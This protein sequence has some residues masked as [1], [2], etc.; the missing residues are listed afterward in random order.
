MCRFVLYVG[1][2]LVLSSLVTEPENSIIRQSSHSRERAEPLN[3]DGFG[4]AWY[5]PDVVPDAAQFRSITPAWSNQ[6]LR[7]LARTTRSACILAH[8]RA[9]SPGLPVTETNTHPFVWRQYAFMHNGEIAGFARVKRALLDRLD[10]EAYGM[11]EGTTDSEHL[12][13]LFLQRLAEQVEGRPADRLAAALSAAVG[14]VLDL[15]A[16]AGVEEP[17]TLN[18]AVADGTHAAVCRF[19]DGPAKQAP[20]LHMHT[21][22]VYVCE[23]GLCRMLEPDHGGHAVLVASE[24]LSADP[25]WSRVPSNHV[26]VIGPG[27]GAEVR[28][29][30][31]RRGAPPAS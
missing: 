18:V 4:V 28:P 10:D 31:A 26:V 12:F 14:D 5:A 19:T 24:P 17:C 13:A 15:C 21:G 29:L 30:H 27:R 11:I 8:V 2:P 25:G 23:N 6:N 20:S 16:A 7:H 3:G 22:K 1:P 9:A